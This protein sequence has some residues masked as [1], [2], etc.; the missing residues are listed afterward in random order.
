MEEI[1]EIVKELIR[2]QTIASRGEELKRVIE[3]VKQWLTHPK[4]S[5]FEY[6]TGGKPSLV[7][8][9]ASGW[10]EERKHLPVFFVGHLDVVDGEPEQFEPRIDGERLWGRGAL[11][12]KGSCAVMIYLF[13]SLAEE[14]KETSFGLMLT[15]DE[16][17]GSA[18][19]VEYLLHTVGWSADFA[20]I[21]DGGYDFHTVLSEKG[22]L[23]FRIQSKGV[24]AHGSRTWEG[25]NAIDRIF[26]FYT[27]LKALFPSEPCNDPEHWHPTLNLGTIQGGKKV[28]IVPDF[29]QAE[30]D[31][32]FP[33]PYTFDEMKEKVERL[34]QAFPGL[35][36]E[37]LTRAEVVTA[38]PDNPYVQKYRRAVGEITGKTP[39]IL[40]EHGATDGRFFAEKGI[41][42]VITYPVGS[43]I[44]T[45]NEWVNIPS[46]FTLYRIF[47]HFLSLL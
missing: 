37:I 32:R 43:G 6:E 7:A 20:L 30:M 24:A 16:E 10:E 28:N 2:Y 14:G 26:Q 41:P 9:Q 4:I 22:A 3:R 1:V 36:W 31:I 27:A 38:Q 39:R 44:H 21:P 15:T 23:H 5:L 18:H 35:E 11:D 19:G 29:A 25:V 47:Q 34:V 46:L 40:R 12:M 17:I 33:E 45:P 13:R 8:V 42:I